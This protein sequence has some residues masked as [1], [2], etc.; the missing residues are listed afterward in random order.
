MILTPVRAAATQTQR[1]QPSRRSKETD[2]V[3]WLE[4]L[5]GSGQP[6]Q[7]AFGTS[8]PRLVLKILQRQLTETRRVG[9]E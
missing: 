6:G 1:W 7:G 5:G 8:T 4:L 3:A 9:N 2:P